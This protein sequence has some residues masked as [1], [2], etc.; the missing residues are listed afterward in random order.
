M[1]ANPQSWMAQF[2]DTPFYA[3]LI[4]GTHDSGTE[5]FPSGPS[6]TQYYKINEQLEGGVRFLDMR[7]AYNSVEDNFHVVHDKDVISYLNFDTVV[8]WCNTFLAANPSETIL[9]SIKQEGSLPGSEDA[10][11]R[12]LSTWHDRH[13]NQGDWKPDL[14]YT[15]NNAV[16]TVRQ[17]KSK[18]I[19]LRRYTVTPPS[20]GPVPLFFGGFSL[21]VINHTERA[22]TFML[23]VPSAPSP[24]SPSVLVE[25]EDHYNVPPQEKID[26]VEPCV[27]YTMGG[28]LPPS[29]PNERFWNLT[30]A[31]TSDPGPLRASNVVNPWLTA[32]LAEI[33]P[34]SRIY[35]V[36]LT[37]FAQ[38]ALWQQ[39]YEFNFR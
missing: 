36:L 1:A 8:E 2:Q 25:F 26:L 13:A 6:R 27:T 38:P 34:P 24:T 14:W 31:S 37:D 39:I 35:G 17:A 4:P 21:D 23:V 30:F 18:I 28:Y 29:P 7:L 32:R 33:T 3:L 19:L 16:P 12:G 5:G 10:F 22:G 9:M 20:K 11:A 15:T